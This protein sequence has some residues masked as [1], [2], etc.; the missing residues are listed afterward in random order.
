MVSDMSTGS[1]A[2]PFRSVFFPF[3]L[4]MLQREHRPADS[5]IG[6]PGSDLSIALGSLAADGLPSEH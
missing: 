2:W 5:A 1:K 3:I 4:S 6:R